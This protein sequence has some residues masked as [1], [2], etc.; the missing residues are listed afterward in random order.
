MANTLVK[1][2]YNKLFVAGIL[3]AV[4]VPVKSAPADS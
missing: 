2:F 4:A 1:V 3:A